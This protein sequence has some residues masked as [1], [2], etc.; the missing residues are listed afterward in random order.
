M[1][2][3]TLAVVAG[4]LVGFLATW[5]FVEV[6]VKREKREEVSRSAKITGIAERVE[7]IP[8]TTT[9]KPENL[10]ELIK[11]VSTKFMLAEVT[12]LTPEGLPIASNSST[13]EEDTATAPEI[14][15]IANN[16]LRSDRIVIGGGETMILAVQ[17]SP[18]VILYAKVTRE[19]S[20]AEI[21]KMKVEV[22]SLLEGLI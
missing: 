14:I 7:R 17:I 12:L 2:Y 18:E 6:G 21:E 13:V 5:R 15:K 11:Y 22:K 10:E 8:E 19:F 20:R 16:L 9:K 4:F 3:E 1:I